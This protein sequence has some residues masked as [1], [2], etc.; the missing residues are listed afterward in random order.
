M[1]IQPQTAYPAPPDPPELP[2]GAAAAEPGW[3]W[4]YAPVGFLAAL[5][6]AGF[7]ILVLGLVLGATGAIDPRSPSPGPA[8]TI[9]G[10]LLLDGVFVGTA[11]LF[12]RI[13]RPPRAWHFGLRRTRL[14]PAVGWAVLGIAS[15]YLF[16]VVYSLL[17]A[18]KSEQTIVQ[19]LALREGGVLMVVGG[20]L[21]IVVAPVAEEVFF[22]GFF[23]KAL[24]T[25]VPVLPA[26]LI[27]GLVFGAIHYTDPRSLLT[28][29]ILA[30]LGFMFCLVYE[31]TGSLYP[32]IAL[33]ALQ[34]TIAFG[35]QTG[36]DAAWIAGGAIGVAAVAACMVLPRFAWRT[37]PAAP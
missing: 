16:V 37:A 30:A 27:D 33:H 19:D 24:R 32:V 12:A 34:N 20:L 3:P 15:F 11:L 10:T 17:V 14:W 4:W 36:T 9:A 25:S 28:L 31:R 6:A 5:A 22:R 35:V 1:T 8:L 7:V 2:V 21:V 18:P 13:K 26:A 23:Y 29:P